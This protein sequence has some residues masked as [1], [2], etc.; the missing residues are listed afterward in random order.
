MAKTTLS[1][2]VSYAPDAGTSRILGLI[3]IK[4]EKQQQAAA[5]ASAAAAVH[6][7]LPAWTTL[8]GNSTAA[9]AHESMMLHSRSYYSRSIK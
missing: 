1:S 5:V 3:V 9:A 7:C 4:H 6:V 8:V 2:A